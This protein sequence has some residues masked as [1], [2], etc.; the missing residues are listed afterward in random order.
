MNLLFI[1]QNYPGQYRQLAP[2]LR[3][4]GHN[5]LGLGASTRPELADPFRLD[6]G[7]TDEPVADGLVRRH[8]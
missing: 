6:Y 5:V 8:A 3:S 4:H 2:L 1:H 7:W